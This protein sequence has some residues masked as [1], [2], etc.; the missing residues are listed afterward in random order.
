M[1]KPKFV[2]F[3]ISLISCFIALNSY[4]TAQP[5]KEQI[6]AFR[7]AKTVRLVIEQSYGEASGVS[8]PFKDFTLRLL[9]YSGLDV[10]EADSEDYDL[11]L[12][13]EAKGI[14]ASSRYKT[15]GRLYTGASLSGSISIEIPG[16][17]VYKKTFEKIINPPYSVMGGSRTPSGAPFMLVFK[18]SSFNHKIVEM[19]GEIYGYQFVIDALKDEMEEIRSSAAGILGKQGDPRAVDPLVSVLLNDE[20]SGVRWAAVV[21]LGKI[22]DP[23]A[24]EPLF[25]ILKT[26]INRDLIVSDALIALGK[27]GDSRAIEYLIAALNDKKFR[28]HRG[29]IASVLGY[30][31]DPRAVE[32]LIA[33]LKD[34]TFR[35]LAAMALMEISGENFGEDPEM[36]K[37]WWEKN[38]EKLLKKK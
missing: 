2:I 23:R 32:P 31:K 1:K 29:T 17:P 22:K 14:A 28:N 4:V 18:L 35:W 16:V 34:E 13:I 27:I 7:S 38:K 11:N 24:V 30:T 12:K 6:E 25:A 36:W 37:K 10:V 20:K 9:G 21:S 33:L 15:Y 26:D 3:S 8:L 5:T 19:M